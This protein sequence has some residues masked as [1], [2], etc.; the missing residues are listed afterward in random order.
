MIPRICS[1]LFILFSIGLFAQTSEVAQTKQTSV[2]KKGSCKAI[3][4]ACEKAGFVRRNNAQ[5][6]DGTGIGIWPNC[7]KS[8]VDEKIVPGTLLPIPKIPP[9]VRKKCLE[10][11]P[12]F[13]NQGNSK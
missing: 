8:I 13:V 9:E 7:I 6:K 5:K 4:I 2:K 10:S 3:K 1:L 12:N 11:N